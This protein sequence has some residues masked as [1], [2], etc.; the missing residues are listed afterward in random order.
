[1]PPI[2]MPT[3]L[4]FTGQMGDAALVHYQLAHGISANTSH[5]IRYAIFFRLTHVDHENVKW[6]CMTD[7]WRE[8]D[9]IRAAIQEDTK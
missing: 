2:E 6:E 9:G 4:Q 3:P 7:I 5:N 8:W 1:M